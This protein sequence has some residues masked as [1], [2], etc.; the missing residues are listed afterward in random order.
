MDGMRCSRCWSGK[1]EEENDHVDPESFEG[2][3]ALGN[4]KHLNSVSKNMT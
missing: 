3:L 1:E 2:Y 4:Y